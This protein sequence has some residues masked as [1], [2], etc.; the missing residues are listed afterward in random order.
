MYV[1]DLHIKLHI[2]SANGTVK[3]NYINADIMKLSYCCF[4]F[5]RPSKLNKN[6][7]F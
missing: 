3:P 5:S 2:P 1:H 4:T 6:D 7:T